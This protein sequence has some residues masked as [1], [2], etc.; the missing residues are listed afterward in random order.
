MPYAKQLQNNEMLAISSIPSVPSLY[1][2]YVWIKQ[3]CSSPNVFQNRL[4]RIKFLRAFLSNK[5]NCGF[6]VA[7]DLFFHRSL[8]RQQHC[9]ITCRELLLATP[10]KARFPR[11]LLSPQR[12]NSKKKS[13]PEHM[14]E[15]GLLVENQVS[16]VCLC[17][18]ARNIQRG[19]NWHW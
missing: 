1:L 7:F 4:L 5:S 18:D 10:G 9:T 6:T 14:T 11:D 17:Q 2:D 15:A 19:K 8:S 16:T 12:V 3:D 13:A